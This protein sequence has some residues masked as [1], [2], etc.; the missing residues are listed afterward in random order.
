MKN[1]KIIE[2]KH[3]QRDLRIF[4]VYINIWN[5][6]FKKMTFLIIL[7]LFLIFCYFSIFFL[8]GLATLFYIYR[9]LFN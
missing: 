2:Y 7:L 5:V 3:N 9:K 6:L 1:D 4:N 8:I